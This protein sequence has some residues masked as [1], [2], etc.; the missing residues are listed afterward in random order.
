[1]AIE[2]KTE[3][4]GKLQRVSKIS[5]Y[6]ENAKEIKKWMDERGRTKPPIATSMDKEE[7]SLF[8]ALHNIRQSVIKKYR[9]MTE[10]ERAKYR[11]KYS[12][13]DEILRIIEEIDRNNVPAPL[14][15]A[16][17]IKKW[18]NERG[19]KKLPSAMAEDEEEKRL[20]VALNNIKQRVIKPYQAMTKE[21][22]AKYRKKHPEIEEMLKIVDEKDEKKELA[23][24]RNARAIKEWMEERETTK[25]PAESSKDEEEKRLGVALNHIKQKIIKPY[26]KMTEEEKVKYRAKHPEIDEILEIVE[27]IDNNK[28]PT[29]LANAR[30]IKKW[31]EDNKTTKPPAAS[32]KDEE[33]KRL[34]LALSTIRQLVIKPYKEMKEEERERYRQEHPEIDEIQEIV[35]RIGRNNVPAPLA[36]ARAIKQWMEEKETTKPPSQYS[37]DEEEKRLGRALINIRSNI[38]KLYKGMPEEKKA[39]YRAK[40]PEIDEVLEIVERIDNEKESTVL[41]SLI[42]ARLIKSWM[43]ERKTTKPPSASSKDEEEKRLGQALNNIKQ[44]IVESYKAMTETQ[45]MKYIEKHPEIDEILEIIERIGR[46]NVPAHLANARTIKKWMEERETTK[47]PSTSSKDEEEKRLGQAL[48][49][50]RRNI[51]KQYKTM[52]KEER[53]EY[54]K[55]HPEID[56]IQGIVE[57]IDKNNVPISLANAREIRKWMEERKT[58]KPPALSSKEE[59]KRLGQQLSNIRRRIIKSYKEMPEEKRWEYREEHPEIDEIVEI[60]EEIDRNNVH[61]YL[62]NARDIIQWMEKNNTSIPPRAQNKKKTVPEEE[63]KREERLVSIRSKVIKPYLA[64]TEEERAKYRMK[65]PEIDEILLIISEIDA[66][67]GKKTE[68]LDSLV[69]EARKRME[70]LKQAKELEAM[71]E[72][73]L[74]KTKAGK[75]GVDI[76][77]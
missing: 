29:P 16:R 21:E 18:M 58:T 32:S 51:M 42:N 7:K 67:R 66:K 33:E 5:K 10:E 25:T 50:I 11:E 34:A 48:S 36:N 2:E 41:V 55:E 47:P 4:S 73:Q 3:K 76:N 53:A 75:I 40:H 9:A 49:N 1:M 71:Y 77:E 39:K 26:K 31:M 68:E 27:G 46:K 35:E 24:L 60:V 63:A 74:G 70:M 54:K 43:E 14:A 37:K 12:E 8:K 62:A 69:E 6:L 38:V 61:P 22:R 52:T 59:E 15:H 44:R 19:R 65:H 28:V 23:Y 56:E 72:E 30:A 20:G 17:E 64:M 13:I 57:E 45:R